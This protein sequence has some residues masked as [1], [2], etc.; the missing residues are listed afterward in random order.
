MDTN[1]NK[2]QQEQ[3]PEGN[4]QQPANG[5]SSSEGV[6][7]NKLLVEA[8]GGKVAN[9]D[10]LNNIL[11]QT[12]TMQARLQ[13]LEAKSSLNPFANDFVA[14][15]NDFF[16]N[17]GT[18]DEFKRFLDVQSLD[19]EQ[20]DPVELVKWDLQGKYPTLNDTELNALIEKQYGKFTPTKDEEGKEIPPDVAAIAS[21]KAKAI[22]V[23]KDL[24]QKKVQFATPQAALQRKQEE[25]A[26]QKQEAAMKSLIGHSIADLAQ[27]PVSIKEKEETVFDFAFPLPDEFKQEAVSAVLPIA[28][29]QMKAGKLPVSQAEFEKTTVP[30]IRE[31]AETIAYMRFGPQIVEAAVRHAIANATKKEVNKQTGQRFVAKEE[32]KEVPSDWMAELRKASWNSKV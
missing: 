24:S 22:E 3:T 29:E 2:Q 7:F 11:A 20:M 21:L 31:M 6:D 27:I 4:N 5:G 12:G 17:G 10:A 18:V 13:E 25:E 1:D 32:G 28:I 26:A 19:P 16:A 14:N 15:A 9:A 23:G 8:T 30:A